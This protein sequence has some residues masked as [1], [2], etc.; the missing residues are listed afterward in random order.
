MAIKSSNQITFTEQKKIVEIQ[1]WYLA[2]SYGSGVTTENGDWGTWTEKVQSINE[3]QCY[4]WN[5]EKTIYSLGEPE[6]SDPAVIGFYGNGSDG[7]G[8]VDI[9]NYYQVTTD[10]NPPTEWLE[11]VP[12]LDSV[13]KYLWNYEVITYTSGDPTVTDP[14]IIGVYG[15][16][17]TDAVDFQIYSTDGFEFD[18]GIEAIELKTVAYRAGE[19]IESNATYQWKWWNVNSE[20]DDKYENI[21]GATE[22]TFI[23]NRSAEYA[24]TSIKCEMT[25]DGIVY[26]DYVTLTEKH[27]AY[28][29]I[30]KFFDGSN[31]FDSSKSY[32]VL[33]VELYKNGMLDEG[34]ENCPY[35]DGNNSIDDSD[36][37]QTDV[38]GT[39]ENGDL[40][41]FIFKN[42][43]GGYY[44]KLGRYADKLWSV[45]D[46]EN[47]Y[48]Y[49][50]DIYS[51]IV[52][53]IIV[54]SKEDVSK[55][56][57]VNIEVYKKEIDSDGNFIRDASTLVS[58]ANASVTD[59]NDPIVS[60][61]EPTNVKNGQL[62]L[63]TSVDPYELKIF[64]RKVSIGYSLGDVKKCTI[65]NQTNSG[66]VDAEYANDIYLV[67]GQGI[68]LQEPKSITFSYAKFEDNDFSVLNDKFFK[69]PHTGDI[70]YISKDST[71]SRDSMAKINS[72]NSSVTYYY[73]FAD[74]A[75]EVQ[76]NE[77]VDEHWE[78]FSQQNGG[79]VYTSKPSSYKEGDLWILADGE[80]CG[81][82]KAGTM[83]KAIVS[84][85]TFD[86][87]HWTDA[88]D[89]V[90]TTIKNVKES[91]YFDDNGLQ[92]RKRVTDS[93]G[94]I[95]T[96]FYVQITSEKM[97]F[98][99]NRD[100]QDQEVVYI[101]NNSATIRNAIIEDDATFNCN[102]TFNEQVQFSNSF[103]WKIES[104][105][106]LSL[107]IS[108]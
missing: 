86:E 18:N 13:N 80:E 10:T 82:F 38:E 100:G 28:T 8:I 16:S 3:T 29:A 59:L 23:V 107:A 88:M 77:N 70:I 95:T 63:D 79:A 19:K 45:C 2:T 6:I 99:D 106:S 50:N 103:I 62:W 81:E 61:V 98:H 26:E 51:D 14:A 17:G 30:A 97:G 39:F 40:M 104:N 84:S 75:Q 55:N 69:I 1:E 11:S 42:T 89:D 71:F 49:F 60:D 25:Y 92:I 34:I 15:D 31:I 78:Y 27:I 46:D 48:V 22:S 66:K 74:K 32:I 105:G 52:S 33:Y 5:Y 108:G 72:Y 57:E 4:L 7:R 54:I 83:L 56:R 87:S 91:F 24:F 65:Y 53:N 94:N 9:K 37:I 93:D 68:S 73:I 64:V 20:L 76:F 96:P 102:A 41:Y 90:T 58:R 35:Y 43:S 36:N 12:M 67:E 44:V 85:D 47:R 21:E 101:S